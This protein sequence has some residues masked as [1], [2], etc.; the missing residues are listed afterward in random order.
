MTLCPLLAV[1]FAREGV[2]NAVRHSGA[3]LVEVL[4]TVGADEL[5]VEI[6]DGG[7]GFDPATVARGMGLANL[8]ARAALAGGSAEIVSGPDAGTVVRARLPLP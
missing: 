5:L 4:V 3:P 8:T 6:R 2:S 1:Q 7:V